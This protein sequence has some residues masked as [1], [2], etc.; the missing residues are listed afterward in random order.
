[1]AY[2]EFLQKGIN[3]V[4]KRAKNE[5]AIQDILPQFEGSRVI[6]NVLDDTTYALAISKE[7]V[8]MIGNATSNPEDMYIEVD[9][10]TA[11]QLLNRKIDL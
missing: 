4:N 2:I 10:K 8:L 7:G 6:I 1:L 5:K 9:S 3:E 11:Q